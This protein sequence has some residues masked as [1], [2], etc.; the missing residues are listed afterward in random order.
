M[1][2]QGRWKTTPQ[3]QRASKGVEYNRVTEWSRGVSAAVENW[4]ANDPAQC[5]GGSSARDSV[6]KI[7][8]E[9]I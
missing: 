6:F 7:R 8:S 5:E 9:L 3:T 1:G 2:G 4:Q